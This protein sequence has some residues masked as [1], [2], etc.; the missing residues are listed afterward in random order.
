MK[1]KNSPCPP[2]EN[3]GSSALDGSMKDNPS[4]NTEPDMSGSLGTP[5]PNM[6]T[7]YSKGSIDLPKSGSSY[8]LEMEW[9]EDYD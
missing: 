7:G 6:K 9:D 4:I 3:K 1:M 2:L 8:P 5:K